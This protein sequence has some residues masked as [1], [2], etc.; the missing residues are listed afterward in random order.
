MPNK[1]RVALEK[2]AQQ[3]ILQHAFLRWESAAVI[4]LTLLLAFFGPQVPFLELIPAWGWLVG[5]LAAE[6]ALVYSSLS[7]VE[8]NRQVVAN[9][10]KNEFQPERLRTPELQ[11]VM[12]EA[13]EYRGRI[14][15]AIRERRD[16]VL[17][18]DLV[19]TA[20]Q[21]DE[22]I[23]EMYDLARRLD[24]FYGEKELHENNRQRADNRRKQLQAQLARENNSA[25]RR[26]IET[27][28]AAIERQLE[29]I[30]QLESAMQRAALRLEN[31]VT[32]MSTIYT[33]VT[34]LG[35]KDIDSGRAQRLRQEI[36]EEVTELSDVLLA[37]DEVYASDA[38]V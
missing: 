9:M 11:R 13:L 27:N 37:M 30:E 6:G 31:T 7:D 26:E 15:S 5:G 28:L 21:F 24:R 33:Q 3:A 12:R 38:A 14:T 2:R 18:D 10:L 34:L 32:A 17:K 23:E 25:V 16:T 22:W 36:A 1:A 4:A 20:G 35:A 19:A 8:A 29:T